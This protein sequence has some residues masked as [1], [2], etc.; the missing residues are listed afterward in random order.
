M[1]K[2]VIDPPEGL[3]SCLSRGHWAWVLA[4][5]VPL[6]LVV[7]C[8]E[9]KTGEELKKEM[10]A[11]KAEVQALKE[12]LNSLE[13]GQKEILAA[14]NKAQAAAKELPPSA[15][16]LMP[17]PP[18]APPAVRPEGA[19]GALTVGELIKNKDRYLSTRVTVKGEPGPVLVHKKTFHLRAPEG[20]VEVVF[21]NLAD[22]AQIER[23]TSQVIPG[24]VTVTGI[25]NQASGQGPS[26]L[27]I[28]AESVE[29]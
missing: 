3:V 27:Q 16:P 9:A 25:L 2:L 28:T 10:Q 15:Q 6:S 20:M 5:L 22:K 1:K 14:L 18:G 26:R 17:P 19:S 4:I 29:F 7:G 8:P 24:M 23:L 13:A 21:G 12:K 11:V